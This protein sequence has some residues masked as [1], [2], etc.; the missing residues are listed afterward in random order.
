MH[1]RIKNVLTIVTGRTRV[2][3]VALCTAAPAF[4]ALCNHALPGVFI[5]CFQPGSNQSHRA[6]FSGQLYCGLPFLSRL[7][8]LSKGGYNFF[9]GSIQ[10]EYSPLRYTNETNLSQVRETVVASFGLCVRLYNCV[11]E[12]GK[13]PYNNACETPFL[14]VN[15]SAKCWSNSKSIVSLHPLLFQYSY[16]HNE[17]LDRTLSRNFVVI[18]I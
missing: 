8:W 16:Q 2:N 3:I 10:S 17:I 1:N 11:A 13:V 18:R 12:L 5:L 7:V 15:R 9:D 14:E 6:L 4:C